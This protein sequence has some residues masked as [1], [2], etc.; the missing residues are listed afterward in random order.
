[1]EGEPEP[2]AADA[3]L[4]EGP[5]H[6]GPARG[7]VAGHDRAAL[8][9]LAGQRHLA[10]GQLGAHAL[11]RLAHLQARVEA[12]QGVAEAAAHG[13]QVA[14]Q[15]GRAAVPAQDPPVGER[16]HEGRDRDELE[17]G[18]VGGSGVHGRRR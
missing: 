13:G 2:L 18:L 7:R 6:R 9:R 17:G 5:L 8:E 12:R 14:R 3:Q 15:R 10:A 4:L 11:D 16:D 1:M